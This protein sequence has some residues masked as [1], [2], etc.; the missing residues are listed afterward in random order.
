MNKHPQNGCARYCGCCA[1]YCGTIAN[2][3]S[4][5]LQVLRN[6]C[7][8]IANYCVNTA[9][10]LRYS[11]LPIMVYFE[12]FN[13]FFSNLSELR[14]MALVTKC[15]CIPWI[16]IPVQRSCHS[17]VVN[18]QRAY[19]RHPAACHGGCARVHVTVGYKNP[20]PGFLYPPPNGLRHYTGPVYQSTR[21]WTAFVYP[22]PLAAMRH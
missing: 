16:C 12:W 4:K 8:A 13:T 19:T 20:A 2:I 9:R 10:L 11:R 14:K 6:Y 1:N 15:M 21:P 5:L 22:P 18:L 7:A 3:Y 17:N